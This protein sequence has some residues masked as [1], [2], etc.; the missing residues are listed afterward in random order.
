MNQYMTLCTDSFLMVLNSIEPLTGHDKYHRNKETAPI[1]VY[2][3]I[4]QFIN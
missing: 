2:E 4:R 3:T 1:L